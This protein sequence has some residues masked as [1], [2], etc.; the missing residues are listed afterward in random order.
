[1]GRVPL[2][3]NMLSLCVCICIL[4]IIG[5]EAAPAPE[6]MPWWY[7]RGMPPQYGD[8]PFPPPPHVDRFLPPWLSPHGYPWD[9]FSVIIDDYP[10]DII[11]NRRNWG[12][13]ACKGDSD[14]PDNNYCVK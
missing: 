2:T 11:I 7:N 13:K 5:I 3:S 10:P 12:I 1:M 6:P 8:I 9:D 14:C 4:F